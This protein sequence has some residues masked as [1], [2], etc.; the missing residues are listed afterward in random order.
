MRITLEFNRPFYTAQEY[1]DFKE[2]YKKLFDM[3]NEQFVIK[4]KTNP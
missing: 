4:K 1:V 3:L 2:F